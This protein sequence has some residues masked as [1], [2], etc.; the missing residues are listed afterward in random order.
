MNFDFSD[1]VK[2]MGEEARK[3]LRDRSPSKVVRR[4]FE[5]DEP[6]ERDLWR[7]M[8]D[9]GW[10]GVTVPETLGGSDL[11]YEALCVLALEL[12]AALAPVPFA[13]SI[14]LAAGALI[15]AGT[16][17]QKAEFLPKLADGSLIGTFALAEGLGNP[18]PRRIGSRVQ[19]GRLTGTKQPVAF[20]AVADVAIVAAQD[21]A[22]EIGL[23]LVDLGGSGVER[24][25]LATLDPSRREAVIR[26]DR[27]PAELLGA[28]GQGWKAIRRI[29]DRAAILIAFEQVGGAQACLDMARDYALERY[30]F[31]RPIG[32][33]QAIKHK[34]ADIYI[35]V[36]LARAH[37]YYGAW[38]LAADAPD[39]GL[40]AASA[41]VAASEA[42]HLASKENIQTHGGMGITWDLDC[43]LYYRRSK[44]LA[45]ELGSTAWWKDR[46]IGELEAAGDAE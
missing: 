6:Y 16:D 9:M 18:D 29:L 39:L 20:G 38:A 36:E 2:M 5:G 11:G 17:G 22:G 3:F 25:P 12:G 13:A 46:L 4:I 43:H 15:A 19:G 30:A 32:S 42:Y 44:V 34:L 45:L 26:F 24:K 41:R 27:V 10:L 14:Y 33:F 28:A 31:G 21:P 8:A 7:A 1:E 35:A 23:Y 40:A 37:A